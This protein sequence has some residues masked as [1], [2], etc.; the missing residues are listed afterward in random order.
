MAID[1]SIALQA[2]QQPNLLQTLMTATQLKGAMAQQDANTAASQAYKASTRPDG[3][4]DYGALTAAL[5]QGPA[6]Y[7]L[8]QIQAQVNEARNSALNYDKG[9]L[10]M[11]QKRTD[12]LSGGFGGLLASGNVTPQA[13]M[14]LASTGIRLGLFTPEEAVNF[15]ADMPSDPGQLMNW[16]RQTYVGFSTDADRLKTLMP[17]TQVIDSGGQQQMMAIDPLTGQPRVTGVIN[18]TMSPGDAN[19]FVQVYDPVSQSMRSVTKAQAAA[20]AN[21]GAQVSQGD[22]PQGQP[23]ALGSGRLQPASQAPGLQAAP[24]LGAQEAAQV[25]GKGSAEASLSLQAQA[26]SAPQSIYQFQN[27]REKLSD[28]NTGPGTD[29]RN[30]AAAFVTG[31]SPEIAAKIGIDPRKIASAEEFKKYATQATLATLAGLG[32]GTDSKLASAAAANPGTQL[33]KLGNQQ[34]IDVLIAGQRAILAKNQ[35]WQS[36]GLPPEQY[37][38][39]STQWSRDIDPRVFVAQDMDQAGRYKML[40]SLPK[41]DQE[42]FKQSWVKARAAGYVQ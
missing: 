13:V 14:Q 3:S 12:L 24:A 8:P 4:I 15:T 40:D 38:K 19:S 11:A 27:M 32:E 7:N 42:A 17:Q 5:S 25:I 18:N 20:M 9:K 31:I 23:G 41:R 39:F 28:I 36:S 16:V 37:N 34:L 1:T 35:A 29:W 10:E 22:L 26:D 33:S 6:A 21:G 2:S 30:T